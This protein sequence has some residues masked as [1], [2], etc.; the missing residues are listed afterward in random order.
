MSMHLSHPEKL[1]MIE[2]LRQRYVAWDLTT[3]QLK[4]EL[5][6]LR[7]TAT[8][9]DEVCKGLIDARRNAK[10]GDHHGPVGDVSPNGRQHATP[11]DRAAYEASLE[12]LANYRKERLR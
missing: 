8:E 2:A 9:I 4:D 7:L 12:W 5:C 6:K 10:G 11:A 3:A 1:E